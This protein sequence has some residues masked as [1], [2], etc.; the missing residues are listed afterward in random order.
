MTNEEVRRAMRRTGL[1]QFE[2][3]KHL[4]VSQYTLSHWLQNELPKE[5]KEF[6]LQKI[7]EIE[8]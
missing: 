1:R 2:I 3:A 7:R 6:I 8:I 4:G 5:K